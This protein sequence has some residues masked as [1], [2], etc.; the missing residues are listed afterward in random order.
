MEAQV[1]GAQHPRHTFG[2][3]RLFGGIEQRP[4]DLGVVHRL[5]EAKTTGPAA[6]SGREGRID[7]GHDPADRRAAAPGH[8]AANGAPGQRGI[9]SRVPAAS[10]V[11]A[12]RRGPVGTVTVEAVGQGP[13]RPMLA[14]GADRGHPD[15][16]S[17]THCS[18]VRA[19][20]SS[21]N[22]DD[23]RDRRP[24]RK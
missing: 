14:R 1:D 2:P 24:H 10:L 8:Q 5:E 19:R 3:K 18:T 22:A 12:Q 13:E 11:P 9:G 16:R 7:E 15:G 6:P 17:R 21:V 23:L 20:G 4:G